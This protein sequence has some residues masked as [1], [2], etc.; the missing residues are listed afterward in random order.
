MKLSKSRPVG[1]TVSEVSKAAAAIPELGWC[2]YLRG[3]FRTGLSLDEQLVH[4]KLLGLFFLRLLLLLGL[5]RLRVNL[6]GPAL[7]KFTLWAIR[8]WGCPLRALSILLKPV[9][10]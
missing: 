10:S 4:P 7:S 2:S 8:V 1:E 3:D 5:L 9:M 6:S